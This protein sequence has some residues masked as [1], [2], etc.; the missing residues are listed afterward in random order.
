MH[1]R[2]LSTETTRAAR[3]QGSDR[4]KPCQ[5][6]WQS[7]RVSQLPQGAGTFPDQ[8]PAENVPDLESDLPQL[9]HRMPE[10]ADHDETLLR[11]RRAAEDILPALQTRR[12]APD[13]PVLD[14]GPDH[15]QAGIVVMVLP[16]AQCAQ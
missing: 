10:H 5:T 8:R 6:K 14:A 3:D 7:A 11:R 9:G 13:E 16:D 12:H 2:V 15:V 4:V 1:S